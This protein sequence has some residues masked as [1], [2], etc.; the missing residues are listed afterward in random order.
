MVKGEILLVEDNPDHADLITDAFEL[1]DTESEIILMGDGQKVI[2]YLQK[3]DVNGY[4]IRQTQ[5]RLVILDLNI[6]KIHGMEVLK[7]IKASSKYR[8]VPVVIFSVIS[9]QET[10]SEGYSNG[11]NGFVTKPDKYEDFVKSIK[12]LR[13][14]GLI[15]IY[16]IHNI[17]YNKV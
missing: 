17:E 9:D 14:F 13:G 2:D 6:P 3:T 8:L 7:F 11:A 16:N 4:D 1:E 10:I 5:I 12:A 15:Q